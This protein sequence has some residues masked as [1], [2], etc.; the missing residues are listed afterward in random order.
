MRWTVGRKLFTIFTVMIVLIIGMSIAGIMSTFTLNQNTKTINDDVF[1]KIEKQT[2]VESGIQSVISITQRHMLSKDRSFEADY[3]RQIDEE[4]LKVEENATAYNEL[5][6]SEQEQQLFQQVTDEWQR[7]LEEI[8]SILSLSAAKKVQEATQQ[9]YEAVKM[10]NAME[11]SLQQLSELHHDE[12]LAIEEEGQL[13]Y[14]SVLLILSISTIVAVLIA[15]FGIRY[16][17]RT[18]KKPIVTLSD[19]FKSM[20][21]GDLAIAPIVVKSQDEIGQLGND[22]NQLLTNLNELI[23]DLTE[24]VDTLASTSSEFSSSADESSRASEQITNS[25]I[26]VSEVVATQLQSAHTSSELVDGITNQLGD[27][28]MSIQQ[29]SELALTT[30]QLTKDGSERMASTVQKMSDIQQSTEQTSTVVHSLQTKSTE[31]GNIVSL[32][33]NIAG[34]TNL[35]ALNASIEAARAGEHGKGFAVVA[36]EVG[37]LAINSGEAAAHIQKLIEEIQQEVQGAIQ[38]MDTSKEFVDDGLTLVQRTGDSFK[39]IDYYVGAVSTQAQEIATISD[40]INTSIQQ[41]KKLV[42]EVEQLSERSDENAQNIVAASEEQSATMEEISA[43]SAV[44]SS[45]AD[46]LQQ[47][48]SKF[49][50]K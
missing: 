2:N 5:L 36:S 35:L 4:I 27:A 24:N 6:N 12:L 40:V 41:V 20:A 3:E 9:S 50:L 38:A 33:T 21:T 19:R 25:I 31:I 43:S 46:T 1:P 18:I 44:L 26:D 29:V 34:Q 32:I 15:I 22:S 13:L 7:F 42:M 10:A 28:V 49:N 39:E 23:A 11:D 30:K 37:K 48:I 8:D 47:T 45:M 16:L 17:L 14:N